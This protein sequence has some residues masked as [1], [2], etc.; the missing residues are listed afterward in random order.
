MNIKQ[1]LQAHYNAA[2]AHYG[3]DNILG[4]FLYGSQNYGTNTQDSDV[5]TKCILL[6][7]LYHLAIEQFPVKDL[8]VDGEKCTCMT[9]MHAVANWK[10]QNINFVEIL[11]THYHIINPKYQKIWEKIMPQTFKERIGRYNISQAMISM[12]HQALTH[13]DTSRN[14]SPKDMM[15]AARI[16]LSMTMLQFDMLSYRECISFND[17]PRI[18][19]KFRQ[20]RTVGLTP[21]KIENLKEKLEAL[22][23]EA[24][25][26]ESSLE[27][28]QKLDAELNQM[29]ISL[30]EYRQGKR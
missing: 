7:D 30:L 22:I 28:R 11:F 15:N 8:M 26:Y 10:K 21:Q 23:E 16:Y 17:T 25:K 9:I 20:I 14:P 5:D 29:I 24:P 2:A 18:K 1:R 4:V 12:G 6:P 27:H 19:E 13:L 3:E